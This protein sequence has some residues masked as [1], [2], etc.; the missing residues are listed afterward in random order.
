MKLQLPKWELT[1]ECEG[2]FLHT[3]LHFREHEMWLLGFPSWPATLQGLVLVVSPRLGL[4][5]F[6]WA[7]FLL[8][9]ASSFP[10]CFFL[11]F[12]GVGCAAFSTMSFKLWASSSWSSPPTR[13]W[14]AITNATPRQRHPKP[15]S[16]LVLSLF[17]A[18]GSTTTYV[19]G[20]GSFES[21]CLQMFTSPICFKRIH[22]WP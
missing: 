21:I 3:L 4:Q 5:H 15:F 19:L 11:D 20:N 22:T 2:S 13:V 6:S 9:P 14:V 18:L 17:L 8:M 7:F 16:F 12:R 1:W 10:I